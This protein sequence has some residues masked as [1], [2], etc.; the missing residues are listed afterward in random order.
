MLADKLNRLYE[1]KASYEEMPK[2]VAVPK[3]SVL[4]NSSFD[5]PIAQES[6]VPLKKGSTDQAVQPKQD[7]TTDFETTER[8][9]MTSQGKNSSG[10]KKVTFRR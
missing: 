1:K 2:P 7:I 3:K 10:K 5:S 9:A 4:K 8:S 6:K